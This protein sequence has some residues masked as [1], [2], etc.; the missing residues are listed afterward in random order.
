MDDVITMSDYIDRKKMM[1]EF[2]GS[3]VSSVEMLLERMPDDDVLMSSTSLLLDLKRP[4]LESQPLDFLN[5][6]ASA[7]YLVYS[8]DMWD[9]DLDEGL[10]QLYKNF[11]MVEDIILLGGEELS[12]RVLLA[13]DFK[14][15]L[16]EFRRSTWEVIC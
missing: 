4:W 9:E 7:M 10:K 13:D 6:L 5:E 8:Y 2:T 12:Y 14:T 16:S 15:A 3:V 11:L 1:S